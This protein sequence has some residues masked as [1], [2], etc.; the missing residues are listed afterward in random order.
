VH[1]VI[2]SS[3]PQ[4]ASSPAESNKSR[5]CNRQCLCTVGSRSKVWEDCSLCWQQIKASSDAA[6][7]CKHQ[8]Q[9][10][11]WWQTLTRINQAHNTNDKLTYSYGMRMYFE[12]AN[13]LVGV[14][15]VDFT[16]FVL[17]K[18][19]WHPENQIFWKP[20]LNELGLVGSY[21]NKVTTKPNRLRFGFENVWFWGC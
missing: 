17:S 21:L 5:H 4:K 11:G 1:L 9:H 12:P 6:D 13:V 14:F 2:S 15:T 8:Q 19:V 3:A 7:D 16:S 18:K 20:N 10:Q